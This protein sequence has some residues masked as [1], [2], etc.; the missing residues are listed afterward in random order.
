MEKRVF[1]DGVHTAII[2]VNEANKT[3]VAEIEKDNVKELIYAE[4]FDKICNYEKEA[5][6]A[7]I[8]YLK[9]SFDGSTVK[10][11]S[12]YVSATMLL[13]VCFNFF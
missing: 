10:S 9:S 3:V 13:A 1:L 6:K 12:S 8:T 4:K 5:I 11:I 2:N 7:V